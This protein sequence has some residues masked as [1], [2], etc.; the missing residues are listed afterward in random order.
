M[1]S[2]GVAVTTNFA[3][4]Q[5]QLM[6]AGLEFFYW[7]TVPGNPLQGFQYQ[8]F[9][10]ILVLGITALKTADEAHFPI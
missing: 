1:Q 9:D 4:V 10:G 3:L 5:L 7:D 2:I 8:R 6:Q